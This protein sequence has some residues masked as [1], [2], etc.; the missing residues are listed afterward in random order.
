MKRMTG[1]GPAENGE[2]PRGG[3]DYWL[4][5]LRGI[6]TGGAADNDPR[7]L[8]FVD[9]IVECFRQG[10]VLQDRELGTWFVNLRAVAAPDESS[11]HEFE[12]RFLLSRER[13]S[14]PPD[15]RE[16]PV[17]EEIRVARNYNERPRPFGEVLVLNYSFSDSLPVRQNLS[18]FSECAISRLKNLHKHPLRYELETEESAA[19]AAG[20][21]GAY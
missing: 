9:T 20:A 21:A 3:W 7:G 16:R 15:V 10:Y 19:G 17:D 1:E 8:E 5:F 2:E 11:P 6:F 12:A 13:F 4:G 14:V 18:F